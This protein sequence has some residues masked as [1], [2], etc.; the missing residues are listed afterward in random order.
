MI[1]KKRENNNSKEEKN[2]EGKYRRNN[3][4]KKLKISHSVRFVF[5]ISFIALYQNVSLCIMLKPSLHNIPK[6]H[7]KCCDFI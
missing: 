5:D 3:K 1:L 7:R 6:L 4:G 2:E